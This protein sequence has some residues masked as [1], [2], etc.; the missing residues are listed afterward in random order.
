M[1]G[2]TATSCA[3][4]SLMHI[5]I[6]REVTAPTG[7]K[8]VNGWSVFCQTINGWIADG[9][10]EVI[11]NLE[12]SPLPTTA[13]PGVTSDGTTINFR[14]DLI[15]KGGVDP[16]P[17]IP[18]PVSPTTHGIVPMELPHTG[19]A[20]AGS[21]KGLFLALIAAIATYGAVYFAQGKRRYNF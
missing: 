15:G 8:G 1:M 6:L 12:G 3:D 7:Y 18:T 11:I 14:N 4:P 2:T 20:D 13:Q 5:V 16:T 17:V 10:A 19:P 9:T 21:P